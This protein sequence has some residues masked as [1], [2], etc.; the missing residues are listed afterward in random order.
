MTEVLAALLTPT[1][2][3]AVAWISFQQ[4]RTARSKLTLD[5]FEKRYAVY[6]NV[7]ASLVL[8]AAHGGSK[9]TGAF[10]S[11]FEAWRES[12]FLFGPEVASRLDELLAVIIK[13]ET[14]EAEMETISEDHH[15]QVKEKWDG[16]KALSLE[17]QSIADLFKPYMLMNDKRV[18]TFGEWLA[19]RNRVRLSYED[20]THKLND[21]RLSQ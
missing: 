3:L 2:A 21:C 10:K 8:I 15:R 19:E 1:I 14:A 7:Q 18:R 5:L 13:I 4:W 20:K 17:R 16:V 11:M 6:Q 9:G 12:Q